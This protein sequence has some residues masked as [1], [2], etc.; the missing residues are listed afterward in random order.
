MTTKLIQ[1]VNDKKE[2]EQERVNNP[3]KENELLEKN[4]DK[5]CEHMGHEVKQERLADDKV[6]M[7]EEISQKTEKLSHLSEEQLAD[8]TS[9][10]SGNEREI[11]EELEPEGSE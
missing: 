7:A 5:L 4:Y 6:E 3:E 9:I 2:S 1:L 10:T 11:T 8:Q